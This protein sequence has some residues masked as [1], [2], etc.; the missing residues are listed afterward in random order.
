MIKLIV[1]DLDG[2]LLR[3]DKSI[4]DLT[5]VTLRQCQERGVKV[6]YATGRGGS[7]KERAPSEMFDGRITMNG[8]VAYAADELVYNRMVKM[9][10]A[11]GLLVACDQYGLKTSAEMSGIHYSNFD[12]AAEWENIHSNYQMTDFSRHAID[13]EKLYAIV[14]DQKDISFIE[15]H[16]P[17]GL[18]L[19]VSRDMLAQIMHVDATKSKAIAALAKH[20]DID[21][22]EVV[23]FGDDLNDIDM[24]TSCGVGVAMGNAVKEVLTAADET[25][26]TND[27]DGIAKWLTNHVIR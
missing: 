16:L 25:C 3:T 7:A 26:G 19:T 27:E 6:A 15:E 11:R 13:A 4:S 24:L 14:R 23:A 18:Y 8:A 10:L 9:D 20:W 17:E 1:M 2:T 22:S 12:V 5:K 21:M